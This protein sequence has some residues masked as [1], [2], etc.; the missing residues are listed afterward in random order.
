MV[1]IPD[2]YRGTF[3]DP[4]QGGTAEFL[5]THSN[6]DNIKSDWKN[7]IC[8]YAK[9]HGA[10]VYGAVGEKST[11]NFK[12]LWFNNIC[13][14]TCW[15][16]YAVMQLSD[17]PAVVA[18]VS[19]H[20]S[21]SPIMQLLGEDEEEVLKSI[22]PSSVQLFMPAGGDSPNVKPGGLGEKILAEKLTIVEF[23]KM[24]HGWT[25]RGD[26]SD[27]LVEKDVQRAMQELSKFFEEN[28]K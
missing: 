28:L 10:K 23:P 7:K 25:V 22:K 5:K 21:H 24:R 18:G 12:L 8:P 27:P 20:P 15:G 14:G 17:D 4:S 11:E 3:N 6:K 19:M 13:L 9:R 26:I 16:S 1:I 2:W